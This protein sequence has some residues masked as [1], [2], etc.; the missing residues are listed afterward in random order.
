M[1][2]TTSVHIFDLRWLCTT[3][4]LTPLWRVVLTHTAV[5]T[6][7]GHVV[8]LSLALHLR[9][10]L[11]STFCLPPSA[12]CGVSLP[13]WH[14]RLS[15]AA[16]L[17]LGN[18]FFASMEPDVGLT[19]LT[20]LLRT[21]LNPSRDSPSTRNSPTLCWCSLGLQV[22]LRLVTNSGFTL[23]SLWQPLIVPVA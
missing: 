15:L 3:C 6:I 22:R 17:A 11:A 10:L 7:S 23:L 16:A 18:V 5:A 13:R 4:T 12:R 9:V 21:W 14:I 20:S 19:M 2:P 1:A 8:D